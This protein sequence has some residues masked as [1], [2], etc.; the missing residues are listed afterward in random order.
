ML[1]I[2]RIIQTRIP[3]IAPVYGGVRGRTISSH[4]Q[5]YAWKTVVVAGLKQV[6]DLR[7]DYS[8]DR[9]PELCHQYGVDYF[10][11]PIDNDRETIAK[12]VKLFPTFCEK[13]DKGSFY[14]A[15]AMGRHR[16]DIAIALYYVM[17]PFVPFEEVPE[18]RGHRYVEKKEFRCDDIAARLNSI[19]RAVT[20]DEFA[21]LGLSA[22]YEAE[23]L[24]RKKHLF[25]VNRNFE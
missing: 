12:M 10:H 18:M 24:R 25:E 16:T 6:I 7:K 14:I 11:Y 20:P 2:E 5:A 9:Y 8:A 19:I 23:F 15:C 4:K 17:H 3:D 1:D 22:D 13:I 21:M